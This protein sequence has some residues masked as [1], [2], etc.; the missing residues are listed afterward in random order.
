VETR[1]Q[2]LSDD[3]R[4]VIHERSL[5]ILAEVGVRVDTDRG[6]A[7]LAGAGGRVDEASRVVRFPRE[8]VEDALRSAPRHFSLGGRRVGWSLAMNE[9]SCSLVLDGEAV[10]A[11]DAGSDERR[12]ATYADWLAATRLIDDLDE[13]GV[14]WRAVTAGLAGEGSAAAVRHW[15]DAYRHFTK[16]VQDAATTLDEASW[17]GEV[18]GTIFGGRRAVQEINPFSFLLCPFSPLV[19]EGSF[20]DAYLATIDWRLPVAV[21]P[22]PLMGLSGPASLASTVVLGNCEVLAVLCLVQAAAPGVP[23]IYAAA[24]AVMDPRTG[25]Y[26]GGAVEHALLGSAATEMAR[27]YG[28]PV[29]ASTGGTD[30]HRPGAQASYE[31]ALGWAL[32]TLSWPDLL[33]G[34]GLVGGSAILSLEQLM[35]DI[36]VF[37]RAIRLRRGIGPVADDP[38]RGELAAVGPAGSFHDRRATRDAVRSGTWLIDR[39]GVHGPYERWREAGARDVLDDAH[40]VV[41]RT[42]AAHRDVPFD[43]AQERELDRLEARAT[44]AG[45][46]GAAAQ[47]VASRRPRAPRGG[48]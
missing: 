14:Y 44:G 12:A 30:D 3:D 39:L 15:R 24:P 2:V 27:F 10:Y 42:L 37:R 17:L 35:I 31:R 45:G 20:T 43:E 32:P 23:V 38:A 16:H 29:Q 33:V 7:I 48:R 40:E 22:M 21:M 9:G 1:L 25:R 8:L 46:K 36:E 26:G 47:G 13:V 5:A 41:E 11:I 4:A 19:L 28:L 34:P 18:L 6:R